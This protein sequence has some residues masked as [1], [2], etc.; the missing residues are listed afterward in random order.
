MMKANRVRGDFTFTPAVSPEA[1]RARK[2]YVR[3]ILRVT[4]GLW[5]MPKGSSREPRIHG[6]IEQ[7]DYTVEKVY[8]ES[9]SGLYVTGNLYRPKGK[10][11]RRPAVL[12]P[13][14]HFPGGRFQDAGQKTVQQ[15]IEQGARSSKTPPVVLCSRDA[16]S[17]PGWDVWFFTTT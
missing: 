10:P 2:Q 14:G 11:G 15:L 16:C 5:P 6:R 4:L 8:F 1:W 12:S 17:L 7:D 3:Q 9:V 13:H